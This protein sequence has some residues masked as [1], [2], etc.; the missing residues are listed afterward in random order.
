M[1]SSPI[2][3]IIAIITRMTT[4]VTTTMTTTFTKAPSG[5]VSGSVVVVV[6]VMDGTGTGEAA[7][8]GRDNF[9]MKIYK[10]IAPDVNALSLKWVRSKIMRQI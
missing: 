4:T 9:S 7:C 10:Y 1:M 8:R 5:D 3:I 6:G 2:I